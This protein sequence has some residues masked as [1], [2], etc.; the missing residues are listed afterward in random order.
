MIESIIQ[1]S[2]QESRMNLKISV[3]FQSP[4]NVFLFS[5]MSPRIGQ[6]YLRII[7]YLY[8][9]INRNEKRLIEQNVCEVLHSQGI[10]NV[11]KV[12]RQ[13]FK[14]IFTHYFEKMFSV[15][16]D[17]F[18]VRSFLDT[19]LNVNGAHLLIRALERGRGCIL[20]TAHWGAVEF[21]PWVLHTQEL[22]ISVI[23]EYATLQQAKSLHKKIGYANI[24][25]ITAQDGENV[26]RRSIQ[27]LKANRILMTQCDEVDAWRRRRT[28]TIS[29]FGKELYF[30]ST[31][32]VLSHRS[33]APVVAAFLKRTSGNR[34]TLILEDV[35]V[36]RTPKSN[37]HDCLS[38]LEK[39]VSQYPE[40]WYQWKK[41][42]AM[43][44]V[45]PRRVQHPK[46]Q[47]VENNP[48]VTGRV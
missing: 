41:W 29:L 9:L 35:S 2:A 25:L 24:E 1:S 11:R 43:K 13:T 28:Q 12:I 17:Y 47:E 39:Y 3:F 14:G 33:G 18:I 6:F 23:M 46:V 34:Y 30:D 40:Q 16:G 48:L 7:G 5:R 42:G 21:M 37:A 19:H 36:H 10:R 44:V 27:S 15:Y 22:P 32:D 20:V 8:Y 31:I 4:A 26:F 45:E 38:L